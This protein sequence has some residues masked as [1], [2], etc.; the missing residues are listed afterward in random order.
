M[1][2]LNSRG[3]GST[4][5][6]HYRESL[7]SWHFRCKWKNYRSS[8]QGLPFA[9]IFQDKKL[10]NYIIES[11]CVVLRMTYCNLLTQCLQ[12]TFQVTKT[13]NIYL[14]GSDDLVEASD[15][16]I[17]LLLKLCILSFWFC[18]WCMYVSDVGVFCLTKYQEKYYKKVSCRQ[19]KELE[20][21]GKAKRGKDQGKM[22]QQRSYMPRSLSQS[23]WPWVLM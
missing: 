20:A 12:E 4:L 15:D 2:L 22:V 1:P 23:H 6:G 10:G 16:Q 7:K 19:N 9:F 18:I 14:K 21:R 17:W 11:P 13:F 8:S 3:M 5:H